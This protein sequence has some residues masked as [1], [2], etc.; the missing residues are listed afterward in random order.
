M[1][2]QCHGHATNAIRY[3]TLFDTRLARP[4]RFV[5]LRKKLRAAFARV[6]LEPPRLQR[7]APLGVL[8]RRGEGAELGVARRTVAVCRVGGPVRAE[9]VHA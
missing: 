3:K 9:Q 1:T 7:N 8:N 2:V 4:Y 5:I 6:T